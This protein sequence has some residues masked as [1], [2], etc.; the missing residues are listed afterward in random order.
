[1]VKKTGWQR[2]LEFWFKVKQI[3]VVEASNGRPAKNIHIR[4]ITILIIPTISLLM[5]M[6]INHHYNPPSKKNHDIEIMLHQLENQFA[7][8]RSQLLA[9]ETENTLKQAQIN[10]LKKILQ[11]QQEDVSRLQQ[12]IQVFHSILDARKGQH[13][14]IIQASLQS[15][16]PHRLFFHVTLVKGG[17]Y[18]RHI[19]GS[20]Q[21]IYHDV[22]GSSYPL[23]FK[24]GNEKLPFQMETHTFVQGEIHA[25]GLTPLPQ[26]PRI[27]LILYNKKGKEIIRKSCKFEI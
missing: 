6:V 23:H 9:S 3:M 27:D 25:A 21:F 14:Q 19:G 16:S 5:G 11:K 10:G 1:M 4:P 22:Q 20:L 17:N 26:H 7:S 12:R 13:V 8:V 18:P 2:L 24:N 15:L